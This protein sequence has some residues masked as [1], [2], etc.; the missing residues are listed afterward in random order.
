M[1]RGLNRIDQEIRSRYTL[2]FYSPDANFDGSYRKL[3]VDVRRPDLQV[4]SRA[5]YYAEAADTV[6]S[7][8]PDD[9]KLLAHVA[10][11][12]ANPVLPL[13]VE[14]N[15]FRFKGETYIV[16]LSLEVPPS[17]VKFDRKGDKQVV[18]FDVVGVIREAPGKIIARLGGGFNIP[19]T[20]EQYETI[21]QNN[22]FFRQDMEL[23]PGAYSIEIVF[24]D[25]LSG[26]IAAKKRELVL[27]A[28]NSEFSMSG[29][30]LSR[31]VEPIKKSPGAAE[32]VDVFSQG[33]V[34][35]RP[36]PSREF[37]ATDNLV[38]LF[39]LYN[40]S[41]RLGNWQTDGLGDI[42]ADERRSAGDQADGLPVDGDCSNA[43]TAHDI[44]EIH[45]A[46]RASSR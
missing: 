18:Q 1:S 6:V 46:G 4:V 34:R 41:V 14:L 9:K 17:E 29:V 31:F 8:S 26:K 38:V 22:I 24:R 5:G 27:P 7:L 13:F 28:L 21:Q 33:G 16:P 12:E 2:A 15:P 43:I 37:R 40:A 25:R 36:L 45:Q 44:C 20:T 35:I 3:K 32:T 23:F 42:E 11:A 30:A 39:E 19:L 10:D